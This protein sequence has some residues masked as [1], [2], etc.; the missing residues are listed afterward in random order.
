VLATIETRWLGDATT[1]EYAT[2]TPATPPLGEGDTVLGV[3]E[4]VADDVGVV[5]LV[6][7]AVEL[8]ESVTVADGVVLAD[9]VL[10]VPLGVAEA[11]ELDALTEGVDAAALDELDPLEQAARA[12]GRATSV[13]ARTGLRPS[14]REAAVRLRVSLDGMGSPGFDDRAEL[15]TYVGFLHARCTAHVHGRGHVGLMPSS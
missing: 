14:L 4:G 9:A 11:D 6:P 10:L 5:L 15:G 3:P 2:V 1:G 7:L 12:N 8:G 13:S